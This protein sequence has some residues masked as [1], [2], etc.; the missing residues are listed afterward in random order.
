MG[1]LGIIGPD[2]NAALDA[3]RGRLQDPSAAVRNTAIFAVR[4]I[5]AKPEEVV[6][7]LVVLLADGILKKV[8][9]PPVGWWP[10]SASRRWITCASCSSTTASTR[11]TGGHDAGLIGPDADAAVPDLVAILGHTQGGLQDEATDALAYIGPPAIAA[12]G[13]TLKQDRD[14]P[15]LRKLSIL[16]GQGRKLAVPLLAGVL[17]DPDASVRLQAVHCPWVRIGPAAVEAVVLAFGDDDAE[18]RQEAR[19][20][21]GVDGQKR[22]GR[23]AVARQGDGR[24]VAGRSRAGQPGVERGRTPRRCWPS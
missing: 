24:C 13:Q 22:Q 10:A 1:A 18:V 19:R 20:R 4:R 3:V 17:A 16:R 21:V 6:P 5:A 23:G 15:A 9:R 14:D 7:G 11:P 8:A 2:A 12:L